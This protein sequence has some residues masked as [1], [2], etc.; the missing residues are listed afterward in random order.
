MEECPKCNNYSV[1]FDS[2]YGQKACYTDG[3]TVLIEDN[4]SYSYIKQDKNKNIAERIKVVN[5]IE[6]EV[7]YSHKL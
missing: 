3:C 6:K 2:H 1:D 5:G 7:M 4:N